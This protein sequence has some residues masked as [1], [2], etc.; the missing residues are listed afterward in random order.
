MEHTAVNRI[1]ARPNGG[2]LVRLKMNHRAD[3]Q[4]MTPASG[5]PAFSLRIRKK[6][7]Q[8]KN[9]SQAVQAGDQPRSLAPLTL[10]LF[11]SR[12]S[13]FPALQNSALVKSALQ[14]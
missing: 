9:S 3:A 7:A 8:T 12:N 10:T 5:L 13:N 11:T 6:D 2:A 1:A 14:Q 4:P